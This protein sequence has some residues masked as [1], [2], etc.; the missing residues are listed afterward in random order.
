MDTTKTVS[1]REVYL[2]S[3]QWLELTSCSL[4]QL[5]GLKNFIITA[6]QN[7]IYELNLNLIFLG[8]TSE[9]EKTH[10]GGKSI[11]IEVPLEECPFFRK[12]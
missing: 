9:C 3:G 1:Q 10:D 5:T 11:N 8:D 12:I 4:S 6:P 2:P 7:Y